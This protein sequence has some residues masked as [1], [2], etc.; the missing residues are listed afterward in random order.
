MDSSVTRRSSCG[1]SCQQSGTAPTSRRLSRNGNLAARGAT[2]LLSRTKGM[3][4]AIATSTYRSQL[5]VTLCQGSLGA[6]AW[7][8]ALQ[9]GGAHVDPALRCGLAKVD[10]LPFVSTGKGVKMDPDESRQYRASP[11]WLSGIGPI[12]RGRAV[13]GLR[14][15]IS[16]C[17]VTHC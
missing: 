12:D 11:S 10:L 5:L 4:W 16:T 3:S 17:L 9:D 7:S 8:L 1:T 13:Q 15:G 6:R 14:K 2:P